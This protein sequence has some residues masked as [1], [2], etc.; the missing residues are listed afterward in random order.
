MKMEKKVIQTEKA[1]KA[2]GPY[3][4]AIQAGRFFYISGQIPIDPDGGRRHQPTDPSGF[5]E[6]QAYPGI[7][8]P[9]DATAGESNDFFERHG[10]F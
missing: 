5:G 10:E 3:S 1:P 4:Q 2:I 6:H 9:D 8:R 7:P